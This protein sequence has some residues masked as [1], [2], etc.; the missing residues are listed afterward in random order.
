MTYNFDPEGWLERNRAAIEARR[1]RGELDAAAFAA[2]LAE[3]E[4]RYDDMVARLDGTYEIPSGSE[5][6]E[7]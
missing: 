7:G 4:R 1:S 6:S 5:Q 3:L 2:E